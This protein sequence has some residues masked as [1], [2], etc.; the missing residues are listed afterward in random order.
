MGG[1]TSSDSVPGQS[2]PDPY[3]ICEIANRPSAKL[4][5]RFVTNTLNPIWEYYGELPGFRPDDVLFFQVYDS[6]RSLCLGNDLL[7]IAKLESKRVLPHGFWG[8]IELEI[9]GTPS[10]AFLKVMVNP[11]WEQVHGQQGAPLQ[12]PS[13]FLEWE[14]QQR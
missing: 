7:G 9:D 11:T 1:L 2:K 14:M 4:K 5:T 6:D 8:E 10:S 3:C 13:A 12:Q